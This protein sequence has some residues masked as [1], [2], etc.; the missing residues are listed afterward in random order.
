LRRL[1]RCDRYLCGEG[2]HCYLQGLDERNRCDA[3]AV[4]ADENDLT[5]RTVAGGM[6][7]AQPQK[8]FSVEDFQAAWLWCLIL[9]RPASTALERKLGVVWVSPPK[10]MLPQCDRERQSNLSNADAMPLV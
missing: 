4:L 8:N 5:A 7:L 9:L 1:T 3:L 6:I 10:L 2:Q